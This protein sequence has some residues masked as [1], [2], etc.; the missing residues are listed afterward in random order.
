MPDQ[1]IVVWNEIPVSDMKKAIAFYNSVFGY[2]MTI[3]ATGPNPIAV[4][5]GNMTVVGGHLYP[6]KPA[7]SG[8]PTVHL[9]VPG[10]VED[11]AKRC[12]AAGGEIVGEAITIP[13][14]RFIYAKD[15]DGNSI[16]LFEPAA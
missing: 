11:A 15:P 7:N 12:R 9:A 2:N 1:P 6:G 10:K 3:D 5:G 8:G 14:G 13:P 4:L 16:G